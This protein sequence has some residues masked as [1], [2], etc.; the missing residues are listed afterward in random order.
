MF[1]VVPL[2]IKICAKP[3]IDDAG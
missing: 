3:Y 1:D 2:K